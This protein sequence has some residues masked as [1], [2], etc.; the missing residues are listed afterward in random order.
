MTKTLTLENLKEIERR[1]YEDLQIIFNSKLEHD[2]NGDLDLVKS[3]EDSERYQRGRWSII[4]DL[5]DLL[6][7]A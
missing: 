4:C 3:L 2:K 7:E 6:E 5:I 1:E